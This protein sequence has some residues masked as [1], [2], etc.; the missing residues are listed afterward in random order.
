MKA[1]L[2]FKEYHVIE[3]IY[4]YNPFFKDEDKIGTPNLFFKIDVTPGKH[5]AI[6]KLGIELGDYD[7]KKSSLYIKA[8]ILG[9]FVIQEGSELNEKEI[10][11]FYRTNAVAILFPYLRS[12]V[13]DLSSK[14]SEPPIILPTINIVAMMK[15]NHLKDQ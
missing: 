5:E 9:L 13:T 14:G 4:K 15:E 7:C 8:E 12:L 3:S 10:M 1:S 2:Q 6:I 11:S